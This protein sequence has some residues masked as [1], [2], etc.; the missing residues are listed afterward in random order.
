MFRTLLL[1]A[2]V[3]AGLMFVGASDAQARHPGCYGGYGYGYPGRVT[4]FRAPYYR[5]SFYRAGYYGPGFY[6][7]PY[8]YGYRSYGYPG[9]GY[10]YGPGVG[11][12]FPY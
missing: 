12:G 6:G 2:V 8:Y 11:F 5:N 4:T 10:S 7:A 3:A 1:A 9:F